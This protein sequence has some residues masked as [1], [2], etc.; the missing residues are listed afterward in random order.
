MNCCST[1]SLKKEKKSINGLEL[2]FLGFISIIKNT[3]SWYWQSIKLKVSG[4]L[5]SGRIR[6][7][8]CFF[9]SGWSH[10]LY[11]HRCKNEVFQRNEHCNYCG[12]WRRLGSILCRLQWNLK[13]IEAFWSQMC[14]PVSESLVLVLQQGDDL[15]HRRTWPKSLSPHLMQSC[16]DYLKRMCN[17]ML[18]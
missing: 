3:G 12:T 17:T 8:W 18:S 11:V 13:T 15:Q 6:E 4:R 7:K 9:I 1:E 14:C 5:S 16:S 2:V 10:W